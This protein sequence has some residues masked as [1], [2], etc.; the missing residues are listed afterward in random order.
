MS[1]RVEAL[2]LQSGL[3]G[4]GN[5]TR[6]TLAC[7]NQRVVDHHAKHVDA[8]HFWLQPARGEGRLDVVNVQTKQNPA[9]LRS[10][11]P[12]RSTASRSCARP[13]E[14][15]TTKTPSHVRL[16]APVRGAPELKRGVS[17]EDPIAELDNVSEDSY[18]VPT[19]FRQYSVSHVSLVHMIAPNVEHAF[20][21]NLPSTPYPTPLPLPLHAGCCRTP[22][23]PGTTFQ[24]PTARILVCS[25]GR[26]H[27]AC[28]DCPFAESC[29]FQLRSQHAVGVN[30]HRHVSTSPRKSAKLFLVTR[31]AGHVT[32]PELLDIADAE[33][34]FQFGCFD[35]ADCFDGSAG[36]SSASSDD[37][38]S[39]SPTARSVARLVQLVP[40]LP[41]FSSSWASL[42]FC[43]MLRVEATILHYHER[44]AMTTV[45]FC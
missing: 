11:S 45:S 2:R 43:I 29:S 3:R 15:N 35:H 36:F 12:C 32:R 7:D 27:V 23:A 37:W 4:L 40:W 31:S 34:C 5:C 28:H 17:F 41:F 33:L 13:I 24:V 20:S 14:S 1:T 8:G 16:S 30:T 25:L 44:L 39:C 38:Q 26:G 10:R 9:N 21:M 6:V 42:S 22:M 18:K 19:M